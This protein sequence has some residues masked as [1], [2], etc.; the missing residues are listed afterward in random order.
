MRTKIGR[1]L[2]DNGPLKHSLGNEYADNNRKFS[3]S[4]TIEK[5]LGYCVLSVFS[6]CGR[7]ED[8]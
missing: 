7:A 5:L 1:L 4:I 3:V 6:V 8:L 2:L